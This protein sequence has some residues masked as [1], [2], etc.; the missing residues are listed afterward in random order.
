MNGS[1]LRLPVKFSLSLAE[2]TEVTDFTMES[3]DPYQHPGTQRH[4][5]SF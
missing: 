4:P 5:R 2:C 3:F 1:L